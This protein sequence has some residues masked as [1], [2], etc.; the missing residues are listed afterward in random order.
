MDQ[1]DVMGISDLIGNMA[2]KAKEALSGNS[3]AAKSGVDR[4]GDAADKATGGRRAEHIDKGRD[5]VKD[6]ID[7]MK[8]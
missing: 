1:G 4:A 7:K 8:K 2:D 5:L 3:D 6:Q